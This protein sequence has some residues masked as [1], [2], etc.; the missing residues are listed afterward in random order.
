MEIII[1]TRRM[2]RWN[3][4]SLKDNGDVLPDEALL[5]LFDRI[6]W[7]NKEPHLGCF[8]CKEAIRIMGGKITCFSK[9]NETVFNL[10][11]PVV[12]V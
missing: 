8:S 11:F 6:Y 1:E 7:I 9:H 2:Q 4:L 5:H 3:C 10:K 12:P